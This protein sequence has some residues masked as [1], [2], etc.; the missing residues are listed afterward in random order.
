MKKAGVELRVGGQFKVTCK[1]GSGAFG[2]VYQGV[3]IRTNEEVAIKV[4]PVRTKHTQLLYETKMYRILA[5]ENVEGIPK[6]HWYGVE[7]DYNVLVFDLLGPS[8]E[9]LF[10]YC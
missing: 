6:V 1:I 4:E 3:N 8:L 9:H 10:N 5:G 2:D 7:G